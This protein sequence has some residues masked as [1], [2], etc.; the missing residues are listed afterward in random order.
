MISH[1]IRSLPTKN[2][3]L[4]LTQKES[5]NIA[6]G[7]WQF[8]YR[9]GRKKILTKFSVHWPPNG[10]NDNRKNLKYPSDLGR[11][12]QAP[13]KGY[14]QFK[15]SAST[16]PFLLTGFHHTRTESSFPKF[17]FPHKAA[18]PG[19]R[20]A[21]ESFVGWQVEKREGLG[22]GKRSR[23][24]IPQLPPKAYIRFTPQ[25]MI[26]MKLRY[27]T[28]KGQKLCNHHFCR[29]YV[30]SP[31]R[32]LSFPDVSACLLFQRFG[33]RGLQVQLKRSKN[34][35]SS[36]WVTIALWKNT[37]GIP[38]IPLEL[39]LLLIGSGMTLPETKIV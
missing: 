17:G 3:Q 16:L 29:S 23:A 12:F 10:D 32:G 35:M 18:L 11:I 8:H 34:L 2:I 37:Q 20:K 1:L 9:T 4:D 33:L 31:G 15:K 6:S 7:F 22:S 21:E 30:N 19:R 5:Q 25:K 28:W 39:T 26:H 13:S 36:Y 27:I 24:G 14:P 38:F